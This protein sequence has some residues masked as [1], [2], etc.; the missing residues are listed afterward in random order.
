[1]EAILAC[2]VQVVQA[3][4]R[5]VPYACRPWC[6]CPV[7]ASACVVVATPAHA[8]FVLQE[9]RVPLCEEDEQG[10]EPLHAHVS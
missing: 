8:P 3:D 10:V 7:Q 1:M 6:S 4:A 9:A 5:H 2:P